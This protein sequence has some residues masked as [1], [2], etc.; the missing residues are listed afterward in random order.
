V[1]KISTLILVVTSVD[2]QVHTNVSEDILP[3]S[4]ELQEYV[5]LEVDIYLQVHTALLSRR[6]ASTSV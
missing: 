5:L 6:T 2:L 3:P 1:V 4:S